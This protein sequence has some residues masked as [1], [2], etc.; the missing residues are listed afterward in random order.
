MIA[1]PIRVDPLPDPETDSI[2]EG[3]GRIVGFQCPEFGMVIDSVG[4]LGAVL[5]ARGR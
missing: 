5:G 2:P 4:R 1:V 3:P